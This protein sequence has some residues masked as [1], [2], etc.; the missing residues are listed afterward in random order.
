MAK[1]T[2]GSQLVELVR[3]IRPPTIGNGPVHIRQIGEQAV[4]LRK[5]AN[6]GRVCYR[7]IFDDGYELVVFEDDIRHITGEI[8]ATPEPTPRY[9]LS[10]LMP[11]PWG[12]DMA[13]IDL[14]GEG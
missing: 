7:I 12:M 1:L 2:T 3:P 6:L 13:M 4:I 8:G 14:G 10:E 5:F 11:E 9:K